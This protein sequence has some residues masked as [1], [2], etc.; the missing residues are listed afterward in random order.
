MI[1]RAMY[2]GLLLVMMVS[3]PG[4]QLMVLRLHTSDVVNDQAS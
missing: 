4:S 3:R 1:S 2:M